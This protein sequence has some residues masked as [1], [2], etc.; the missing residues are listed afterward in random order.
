MLRTKDGISANSSTATKLQTA[1][2]INGV[3]FDGTSDININ[4]YTSELNFDAGR[5]TSADSLTAVGP[6]ITGFLSTGSM[7]TGKPSGDGYITEYRWDNDGGWSSQFYI[8]TYD[9]AKS[10]PQFRLMNQGTWQPWQSFYTTNNKPVPEEIG[11]L[12]KRSPYIEGSLDVEGY[13]TIGGTLYP[14]GGILCGTNID[15]GG[16]IDAGSAFWGWGLYT[17]WIDDR[18][19]ATNWVC[20]DNANGGNSQITLRPDYDN[21][22]NLGH[23]NFTWNYANITSIGNS[24][25]LRQEDAYN[26]TKFNDNDSMYEMVKNM[27]FYLEQEK[28]VEEFEEILQLKET[29]EYKNADERKQKHMIRSLEKSTPASYN[30]SK[31][32]KLVA[33]AEELPF[34]VAPE[35]HVADGTRTIETGAFMAG[36][37]SALQKAIEKI[38]TLEDKIEILENK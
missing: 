25:S 37:A 10:H 11:A 22:G 27:N 31:R 12:P 38:E 29:E 23:R 17:P 19:E 16:D 20:V 9:S 21:R 32:F 8:P 15:A 13:A 1:R 36:L 34:E 14:D 3:K 7:T 24:Y 28:S 30:Y 35:S 5:R 2:R 6:S 26:I 33:N 4:T 18:V